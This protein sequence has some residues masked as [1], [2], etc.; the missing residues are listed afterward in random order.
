MANPQHLILRWP[1]L[2]QKVW[3]L[4]ETKDMEN[5]GK[6]FTGSSLE[7][8]VGWLQIF[9]FCGYFYGSYDQMG[10]GKKQKTLRAVMGDTIKMT[11]GALEVRPDK[12]LLTFDIWFLTFDIQSMDKWTNGQMDQWTNGPIDQWK[13][14]WTSYKKKHCVERHECSKSQKVGAGY[15]LAHYHHQSSC[16]S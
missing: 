11:G 5:L 14:V 13:L 2:Q 4:T 9:H 10:L 16:R 1:W 3:G 6:N 7:K 8:G 15:I 12:T